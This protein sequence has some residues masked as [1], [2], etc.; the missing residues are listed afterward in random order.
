MSNKRWNGSPNPGCDICGDGDLQDF[1]D[2]K[3]TQG[4]WAV[5]CEGC[6]ILHGTGL[7]TGFGQR[8]EQHVDENT[9]EVFFKEV[10][11]KKEEG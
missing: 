9:G 4:P 2:G 3:T 10:F 1:I 8:Y 11:F 7:G 5:M 6:F